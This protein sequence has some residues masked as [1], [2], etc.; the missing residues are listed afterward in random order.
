MFFCGGFLLKDK[1]DIVKEMRLLEDTGVLSENSVNELEDKAELVEDFDENKSLKFQDDKT[2]LD[3]SEYSDN[4]D[5][6]ESSES[7]EKEIL[8]QTNK[9]LLLYLSKTGKIIKI[10]KTGLDLSGFSE[11]EVVGEFFWKLPGVFSKKNIPKYLRIYKDCLK[12]NVTE[13]FVCDLKSKSGKKHV[14]EFSAVPI[15]KNNSVSKILIVGKDLTEQKKHESHYKYIF[16]AAPNGFIKIDNK[17]FLT[18][19]NKRLGE[20]L[21]LNPEKFIGKNVFS[22]TS[23][24]PEETIKKMKENFEKRI[25]GEDVKPYVISVK[26]VDGTEL[27]VD[28]SG[29]LIYEDGR[30]VGEIVI[31]RDI[32]AKNIAE[33]SYKTIF[34]SSTDAIFVHDLKTGEIVD[35]NS[36]VVEKFGYSKE[37]I[38]DLKIGDLSVN[39]PPYT[40]KEAKEWMEKT[41]KEGPQKFEWLSKTK[42]DSLIWH[43]NTLRKVTISGKDRIIVNA[44]DITERKKAEKEILESEQKYR[45]VFENADEGIAVAQEGVLKFVNPKVEKII[46]FSKDELV[47]KPFLEFI[48]PEDRRM[49]S[50][51]Y[52][53]RLKDENVPKSYEFRVVTK[54]E[55]LRYV[56][57]SANRI[58]WDN[59]IA[60][61]NFLTDIT[62]EKN[63]SKKLRDSEK[64]FRTLVE[65]TTVGVY[66]HDPVENKVLYANPLVRKTLGFSEDEFDEVDFYSYVHPE[67]VK[68]LKERT[69]R[70]LSGEKIN[71][72]AE[73]R[74]YPSDD[75]MLWAR[76]YT[77]F[78]EYNGRKAALATVIDITESKKAQDQL[79]EKLDELKRYKNVTI[80]R[81]MRVVE[82][83]KEIN[84][85]LKKHGEPLKYIDTQKK[86]EKKDTF[87][88]E[89]T[90]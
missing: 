55:E 88:Q 87:D 20:M 57:I 36:R 65:Q 22:L 64:L 18:D 78:I 79:K 42:D 83:K 35:V 29:N 76:I 71:P 24:F 86:I 25:K 17:G 45:N 72:S 30:V 74:L 14:M 68:L 13:K 81:E 46:G 56:R 70:R 21:G 50:D 82:L 80:G 10:N 58:T 5:E 75:E 33:E 49:V 31:L 7:N 63:L 47:S 16:N 11:K 40:S 85:I 59:K 69:K 9:N 3:F 6:Y 39:E 32:T 19:I 84:E 1:P 34:N 51:N 48:H 89:D 52:F 2:G 54:D 53:K 38:K 61:L 73:I 12:G 26:R 43:E 44:R 28:I 62:E 90:F 37:E 15:S 67:D 60:T 27:F 41:L 8:F 66:I 23:I 4:F 77:N